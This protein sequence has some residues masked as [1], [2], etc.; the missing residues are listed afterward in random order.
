MN[1]FKYV[2]S[3]YIRYP[4]DMIRTLLE[5]NTFIRIILF[6]IEQGTTLEAHLVMIAETM[7]IIIIAGREQLIMYVN[8]IVS[9]KTIK[10]NGRSKLEQ[11]MFTLDIKKLN[12][13][14]ALIANGDINFTFHKGNS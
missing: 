1:V 7:R 14:L 12:T 4:A 6:L 8:A 9:R 13:V 3:M 11:F 5:D 2:R 10:L